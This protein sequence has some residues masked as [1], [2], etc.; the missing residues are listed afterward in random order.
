MGSSFAFW[1][2][3]WSRADVLDLSRCLGNEV[4]QTGK[5]AIGIWNVVGQKV[6][7]LIAGTVAV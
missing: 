6:Q 2:A 3:A 1:A 7:R 5:P 4:A